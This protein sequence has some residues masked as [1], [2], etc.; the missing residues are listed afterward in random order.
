MN[1]PKP[2]P[3]NDRAV[4]AE[5]VEAN[6]ARTVAAL[7]LFDRRVRRA[8]TG[9]RHLADARAWVA[10]WDTHLAEEWQAV[11]DTTAVIMHEF[12]RLLESRGVPHRVVE[13]TLRELVNGGQ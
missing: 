6:D 7:V 13:A 2:P 11:Q 4:Y 9:P 10:L 12:S 8:F 1:Q 5:I 3:P